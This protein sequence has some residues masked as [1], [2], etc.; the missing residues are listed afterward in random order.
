M[1]NYCLVK[2][3]HLKDID[4]AKLHTIQDY[5][6]CSAVI[7]HTSYEEMERKVVENCPPN[8]VC[9]EPITLHHEVLWKTSLKA[10]ENGLVEVD[11]LFQPIDV[12]D[13]NAIRWG[14]SRDD[15]HMLS[16]CVQIQHSVVILE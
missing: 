10:G 13:Y 1:M 12:Y 7:C 2:F 8:F 5:E 4:P 6:F 11:H 9:F 15:A 14:Q 3:I 16:V